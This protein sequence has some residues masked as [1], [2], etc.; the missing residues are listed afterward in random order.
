MM[1]ILRHSKN[2]MNNGSNIMKWLSWYGIGGITG[3]IYLINDDNSLRCAEKDPPSPP[4]W[5]FWFK[6]IMIRVLPYCMMLCN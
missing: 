6:V 4:D 3:Y 5:P 2:M 1:M